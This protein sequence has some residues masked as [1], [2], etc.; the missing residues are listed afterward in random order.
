MKP[1]APSKAAKQN[2]RIPANCGELLTNK[3]HIDVL[4]TQHEY[5]PLG[6]P[7]GRISCKSA[8]KR[9]SAKKRQPYSHKNLLKSVSL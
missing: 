6:R 9:P 8:A 1:A 3:F 2:G 4:R 5:Y 7:S